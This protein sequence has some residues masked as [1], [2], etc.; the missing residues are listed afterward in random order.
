MT[1][2]SDTTADVEPI[3]ICNAEVQD[4]FVDFSLNASNPGELVVEL[5]ES[6][7]REAIAQSVTGPVE[8]AWFAEAP[9]GL[10]QRYQQD[11]AQPPADTSPRTKRY[12]ITH[13]SS[14]TDERVLSFQHVTKKYANKA[15]PYSTFGITYQNGYHTSYTTRVETAQALIDRYVNGPL[16]TDTVSHWS[17][18]K[19]G[20]RPNKDYEGYIDCDV[21]LVAEDNYTWIIKRIDD[22]EQEDV[23][24][25][26]NKRYWVVVRDGSIRSTWELYETRIDAVDRA[27]ALDAKFDDPYHVENVEFGKEVALE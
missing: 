19:R 15:D 12:E 7:E 22:I 4:V 6:I 14:V 27:K 16:G 9:S 25:D 10:L 26:E 21:A 13:D 2:Q 3:Q 17:R 5:D 20:H 18:K 24:Y 1:Q 8:E 23:V 11:P